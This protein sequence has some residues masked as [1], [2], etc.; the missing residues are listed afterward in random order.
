MHS[1]YTW[2]SGLDIDVLLDKLDDQGLGQ[3]YSLSLFWKG[4]VLPAEYEPD[5][6]WTSLVTPTEAGEDVHTRIISV[7]HS[8]PDHHFNF[9]LFRLF[10]YHELLIDWHQSDVTGIEQLLTDELASQKVL[11]PHRLGRLLYDRFNDRYEGSKTEFLSSA[12]VLELLAETPPGVYHINS[13]L[14]GPLGLLY[15]NEKRFLPPSLR[16]PLWHCSDTGCRHLHT[17]E[18]LPPDL[19]VI[20]F[21]HELRDCMKDWFGLPSEWRYSLA[22]RYLQAR[23]RE[24]KGLRFYDLPVL[25]A[26]GILGRERTH[27][28]EAALATD[29]GKELRKVLGAPPRK[30]SRGQG[31]PSAVAGSL[32]PEEQLQLLLILPDVF[33]IRLIDELTLDSKINV[34]LGQIRRAHQ[35]PPSL[36]SLS[37]RSELSRLGL[38]SVKEDPVTSFIQVVH[39]AYIENDAIGD[40]LWRLHVPSGT[41]AI[42]GLMNYLQRRG[43][44]EAVSDLILTSQSVTRSVCQKIG[45]PTERIGRDIPSSVNQILWKFGFNPPQYD[46]FSSR[47]TSHLERFEQSVLSLPGKPTEDDRERIR[48]SGVNLFVCVEQM[49][50]MLI[51]FNVWLLGTDHFLDSRHDFDMVQARHRVP[52]MLGETLPS[53]DLEVSWNPEGENPLGVLLRYLSESVE[54][55]K[56]LE[57]KNREELRRPKAD[58]PHFAEALEARFPFT[59][60]A[61]WA[62]A[63]MSELRAYVQ[64]YEKLVSLLLQA[65][66]AYIRNGLD[67]MR[68]VARFPTSEMML[69]CISRLRQAHHFAVVNRYLPVIFWLDRVETNRFGLVEYR[70]RDGANRLVVVHRPPMVLCLKKPGLTRPYLIAPGN[71]LGGPNAA[72]IFGFRERTEYDDYWRDYP[73]RRH[74]NPV[75]SEMSD[76]TSTTDAIESIVEGDTATSC[77]QEDAGDV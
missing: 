37:S 42:D 41:S 64:Q 44:D 20:R 70:F 63:D 27:L 75:A 46:E 6:K 18:L 31:K 39:K 38:R 52:A 36:S 61:L 56:S 21:E 47:L 16:L 62:D 10:A 43:P 65:E 28:V 3:L 60:I 4:A 68:D 2:K 67:H 8:I 33:L 40:L 51:S 74:I 7:T 55:M 15:S 1:T 13:F 30:K 49:L 53:E 23:E 54:W 22:M 34:S 69:A 59:H 35:Y 48:S 72:I 19:A 77:E 45:F 58:I 5:Q 76:A 32:T 57:S 73:R 12:E 26:D 71:L 9:A 50:D 14:S 66:L 11:L 17:V 29:E 25:I 24:A